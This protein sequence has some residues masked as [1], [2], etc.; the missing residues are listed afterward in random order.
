M[1]GSRLGTYGHAPSLSACLCCGWSCEFATGDFLEMLDD[2]VSSS[3]TLAS[4]L[5]ASH[6]LV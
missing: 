6:A 5:K 2:E 1:S 3:F 4:A